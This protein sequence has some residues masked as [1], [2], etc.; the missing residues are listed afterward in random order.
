MCWGGLVKKTHR[1]RIGWVVVVVV[2]ISL[3]AHKVDPY[4]RYKWSYKM[5]ENT[6]VVSPILIKVIS[7]QLDPGSNLNEILSL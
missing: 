3:C 1:G 6:W 5:A 7:P 4:N 2:D